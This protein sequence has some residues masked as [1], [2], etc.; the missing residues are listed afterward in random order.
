LIAAEKRW[1]ESTAAKETCGTFF[2]RLARALQDPHPT[3]VVP[4]NILEERHREAKKVYSWKSFEERH[5]IV[6]ISKRGLPQ[7]E[8]VM[9]R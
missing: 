4:Y 6:V 7:Q 3:L 2:G 5:F 9:V 8:H 1:R